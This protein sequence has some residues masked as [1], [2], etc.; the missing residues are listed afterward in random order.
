[1][2]RTYT[3]AV[4]VGGLRKGSFTRRLAEAMIK[5][6]PTN[7][8]FEVVEIGQ[9]PLYNQDLDDNGAPSEAW[10]TFRRKIATVDAVLFATPEYNRSVPGVLKNALD[11]GSRPYGKSVWNAKPV[12]VISAS[13]GT[14]GG[15]GANHHLRQSLVYLNMPVLQQPEAYIGHVAELV[16]EDRSITDDASRKFLASVI[17]AFADWIDT[18]RFA[19]ASLTLNR[20]R[21]SRY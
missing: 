10:A 8:R 17:G 6:S 1:M 20:C 13:P 18:H 2:T 19:P 14:M 7:L 4:L 9:L 21:G 3:V 5:L 12:A 11:V 16:A 15:F